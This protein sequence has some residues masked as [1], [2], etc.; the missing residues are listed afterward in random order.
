MRTADEASGASYDTGACAC[1]RTLIT[2][3]GVTTNDVMSEPMHALT[4]RCNVVTSS[5]RIFGFEI[6]DDAASNDK[7]ELDFAALI[8][9]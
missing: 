8:P 4:I 2:S 7:A 5:S 3:K 9:R 1:N 6:P